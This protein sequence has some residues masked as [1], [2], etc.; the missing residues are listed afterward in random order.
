[1][2]LRIVLALERA[3]ESTATL[4]PVLA[5][6]HSLDAT[7]CA[8]FVE[9]PNLLSYATLPFAKEIDPHSGDVRA[10]SASTL[11]RSMRAE[12]DRAQRLL[13]EAARQ[14][15]VAFSFR[16]ARGEFEFEARAEGRTGDIVMLGIFGGAARWTD[17]PPANPGDRL[18][19]AYCA[20]S[21]SSARVL[22]TAARLSEA[23]RHRLA[24][25]A[26]AA[27]RAELAAL[28]TPDDRPP[29]VVWLEDGDM[30]D[31]MRA[32]ASLPVSVY[33]VPENFA[34]DLRRARPVFGSGRSYLLVPVP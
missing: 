10:L 30:T 15:S 12:A 29:R 14:R 6:A 25:A 24:I 33:V 11:E 3:P 9:N 28:L 22:D 20:S 26:P 34:R 16:V 13:R 18:V 17:H 32:V 19:A 2:S 8:V 21:A 27:A 31:F 23:S 7:L 4:E 5:L 1:M